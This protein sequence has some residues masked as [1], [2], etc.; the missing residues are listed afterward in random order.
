V[1]AVCRLKLATRPFSHSLMDDM[2]VRFDILPLLLAVVDLSMESDELNAVGVA[3]VF[4]DEK[5]G[6]II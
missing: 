6:E 4:E 2:M 3:C 1:E 5:G